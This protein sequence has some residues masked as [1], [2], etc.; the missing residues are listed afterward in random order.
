M[1]DKVIQNLRAR[2]DAKLRYA[3]IHLGE[4]KALGTLGG[5]DFDRAHQES[6]LFHLLGAKEAFI[7]EL[8]TYYSC[9][10]PES[11]LTSGKLRAALKG[12]GRTSAELA[13][14]YVLEND[15]SSWLFHAKEMRDH[16]THVSGVA[17][18]FHRGGPED[19][20]V[21]LRNPKTGQHIER[22]F[23]E[24]FDDWVSNMRDILERLR[25]SAIEK[26]CSNPAFESGCAKARSH[27]I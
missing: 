16:S 4:L 9:G 23:V 3:E 15:Q 8:N 14:L 5:S 6:F 1:D 26:M 12:Q 18:A 7:I 25:S 27:S 21:W 13:E 17:R 24:A 2:A 22:H 20:Q 10:L 11:D 19:G